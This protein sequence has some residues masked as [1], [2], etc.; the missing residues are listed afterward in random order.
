MKKIKYIILF[1][2]LATTSVFSK[3]EETE[4]KV[5]STLNEV[6]LYLQNA[7]IKRTTKIIFP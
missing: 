5:T 3:A 1:A 2:L 4:K 6:M 7:Q